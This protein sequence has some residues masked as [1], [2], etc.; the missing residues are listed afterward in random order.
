MQ[1]FNYHTHTYRCGHADFNMK[2]EDFIIELINK[3]FNEMAFTDHVPSN[4]DIDNQRYMRMRYE[5]K[6]EYLNSIKSLKDKYKDKIDIK[7]GFEIEYL[8][9]KLEYLL[10][11]KKETDI[12]VLGQHYIVGDEGF[13][14]FRHQEFSDS[15]LIK[16]AEHI[17]E[18]MEKGIP[19]IIVHPDLYMLARDKFGKVETIV[20][21]MILKSAEK[22]KIPLEI[23]LTEP[24]LYLAN[25][26]GKIV[27]PCKEFWY[28]A[29]KY[30][31]KV[32]YGIDAHYKE[33][34]RFY[35]DSI[36]LANKII[37]E[38]IINKLNFIKEI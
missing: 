5:E 23:N 34:I 25:R 9:S 35:E 24:H 20:A 2:D 38:E 7:V 13:K 28:I 11:L 37:G 36:D 31:V 16:Y 19:D 30:N 17:C 15:D 8:P 4:D 32:L 26:K 6:D 14:K 12:L 3:G 18:A 10:E 21:N 22:Y 29:S 27:Y 1:K 33:Q